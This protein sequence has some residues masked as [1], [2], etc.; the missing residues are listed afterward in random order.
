MDAY[1]FPQV[2]TSERYDA[3]SIT[4][5]EWYELHFYRP[6]D[7]ETWKWDAYS[8]EQYNRVCNKFLHRYYDRE[9]SIPLASRWKRAYLRRFDEIMPKY[10]VLYKRLEEGLDPFQESRDKEKSRTIYSEFPQTM[11]SGNSDYASTGT[12]AE[13]DAVREGAAVDMALRFANEWRDVDA[14][15]LD[16]VEHS[17]FSSLVNVSLPMW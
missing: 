11:L 16:E 2:G 8:P 7:D 14:M 4:L 3:V 1:N 9:V 12:D 10:K 5:G 15:I 13:R 17:L 6:F